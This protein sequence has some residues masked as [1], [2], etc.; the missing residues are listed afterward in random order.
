MPILWLLSD[1][2]VTRGLAPPSFG[3]AQPVPS[4]GRNILLVIALAISL[5]GGF[6]IF[7]ATKMMRLRGYGL[8]IAASILPMVAWPV[9]LI[10]L[11]IG[12]WALVVLSQRDVRAAFAAERSAA[13]PAHCR[14]ATTMADWPSW[15]IRLAGGIVLLLAAVWCFMSHD[16]A[17]LTLKPPLREGLF[18]PDKVVAMAI[19]LGLLSLGIGIL[20]IKKRNAVRVVLSV[21]VVWLALLSAVM[22]SELYAVATAAHSLDAMELKK[23]DGATWTATL[24]EGKVELVAVS[25]HPSKGQPWW[26]PDGSPYTQYQFDNSGG[27]FHV[28]DKTMDH[29]ELVFRLPNKDSWLEIR[30]SQ[31]AGAFGGG[32]AP[33]WHKR[34]LYEY[35][36]VFAAF[37]RTATRV[38]L[39]VAVAAGKWETIERRDATAGSGSTGS[40]AENKELNTSFSSPLE[41]ADGKVVVTMSVKGLDDHEFRVVAVDQQGRTH[42]S[43]RQEGATISGVVQLTPT[44]SDLPLKQIKEFLLQARPYRQVEFHNVALQPDESNATESVKRS[45]AAENDAKAARLKLDSAERIFKIVEMQYKQGNVD[46]E[47]FLQAKLDRDL[48][49]AELHGDAVEAARAKLHYAEGRLEFI[50]PRVKA[51]FKA[52]QIDLEK[53]RLARDQA[54][55]DLKK[56]EASNAA[57]PKPSKPTAAESGIEA[58]I[59][60]LA[61]AERVLK[62]VDAKHKI[63]A[64]TIEE[65]AK[66]QLDR[67]LA[68][69]ELRADAAA[70]PLAQ[71][72]Y[73]HKLAENNPPPPRKWQGQVLTY[74]ADSKAMPPH[75]GRDEFAELCRAIDRRLNPGP[76]KVARVNWN[77]LGPGTLQVLVELSTRDNAAR[78]RV[79]RLLLHPGTLEFRV[80]ANTHDNKDLIERAMKEPKKSELL[81]PAGKRLAWWAPVK[82]GEERVFIGYPDIARRTREKGDEQITE[83]LV[84]A[85]P[86]NVTGEDLTRAKAAVDSA[87]KPCVEFSLKTG[88]AK[89]LAKLTGEHL[90][91]KSGKH[92]C[93]LGIILDGQL[94]SA[95]SIRSVISDRGEITGVFTKQDVADMADVLNSGPLPIRLRLVNP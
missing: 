90:P 83:V 34:P 22:L 79:E 28:N 29:R 46:Y 37:P 58:A 77:L 62:S 42:T 6:M 91:D 24:P 21:T 95:P 10:G 55:A 43:I 38:D 67:D 15:P 51:G 82:P 36:T 30:K 56:L 89:R 52:T 27:S 18:R 63:G 2:C 13:E 87:G 39:T 20:S 11:P 59:H 7:A 93:K 35:Q 80:L 69:A 60:R 31:P 70:S 19:C 40:Y 26:K 85:D 5:L 76:Q 44:F 78:Q 65:L 14:T 25:R 49:A 81:D 9:N 86:Y 50:E 68:A 88:G 84:V 73:W 92:T 12:I 4:D 66:A 41:T 45:P 1:L 32:G 23:P 74:E 47:N 8:A 72:R 94:Q 3:S 64:A 53:A 33:T 17:S 48:A 57:K 75:A 71:L 54:A 61:S 16:I